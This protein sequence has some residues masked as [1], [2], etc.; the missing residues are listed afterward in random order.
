MPGC[1]YPTDHLTIG[2][3]FNRKWD[4]SRDFDRSGG[5]DSVV[6]TDGEEVRVLNVVDPEGSNVQKL[7]QGSKQRAQMRKHAFTN[8]RE[9]LDG[10]HDKGN[11]KPVAPTPSHRRANN[12]NL[13]NDNAV[14][15]EQVMTIY[16]RDIAVLPDLSFPATRQPPAVK[17][18]GNIL[19]CGVDA[20]NV[21]DERKGQ[22]GGDRPRRDET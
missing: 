11:V 7:M 19:H 2:R 9:E 8:P 16:A 20:E 1:E 14:H 12:R 18:S 6:C 5:D 17:Q 3:I 13:V 4:K 21:R 22:G 10:S 15:L